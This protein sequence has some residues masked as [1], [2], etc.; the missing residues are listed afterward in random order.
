MFRQPVLSRH[1]LPRRF[2]VPLAA[3]WLTPQALLVL[4]ILSGRGLT[5]ALFDPR[6]ALPLLLMAL[7]ALYIWQ[8]GVD[9]L[10]QGIV[11]RV[12]WPRYYPYEALD[13]WYLDA[14]AQ[15]RVL[16]VWHKHR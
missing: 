12:F 6:F 11:A 4:T 13:T 8:E 9:V 14:R 15:R 3:L 7:P 16:T 5:P 1:R 10:P 2:R